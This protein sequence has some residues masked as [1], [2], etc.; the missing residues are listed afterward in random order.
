MTKNEK[1]SYT[2]LNLLFLKIGRITPKKS[3]NLKKIDCKTEEQQAPETDRLQITEKE[4]IPVEPLPLSSQ[5]K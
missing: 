1:A 3:Q 2:L 5:A 4:T